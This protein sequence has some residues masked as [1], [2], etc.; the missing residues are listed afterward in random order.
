MDKH[1][2]VPIMT[3]PINPD[4]AEGPRVPG[5]SSGHVLPPEDVVE[6]IEPL[7]PVPGE[8]G[9][10]E[11]EAS[12]IHSAPHF[13]ADP[14]GISSAPTIR[15]SNVEYDPHWAMPRH[16]VTPMIVFNLGHFTRRLTNELIDV[17]IQLVLAIR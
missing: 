11:S 16:L 12:G 15:L 9:H 17:G 2:S 4:E 8:D 3:G 10:E 1:A 14:C 6:L 5:A 13:G 7:P